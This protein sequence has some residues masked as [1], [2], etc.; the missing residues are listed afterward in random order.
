[1]YITRCNNKLITMEHV[2]KSTYH[3]SVLMNDLGHDCINPNSRAA[4][5]NHLFLAQMQDRKAGVG[6]PLQQKNRASHL[7]SRVPRSK[8]RGRIG[9]HCGDAGMGWRRRRHAL[10][11]ED[12]DGE[13]G[14]AAGRHVNRAQHCGPWPLAGSGAGLAEG[15]RVADAAAWSRVA[16]AAPDLIDVMAVRLATAAAR[17]AQSRHL[18]E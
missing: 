7:N 15:T 14:R 13:P 18:M 8:I 9:T 3:L 1:M 2:G 17:G 11:G 5:E 12:F 16:A 4:R 6:N 10:L